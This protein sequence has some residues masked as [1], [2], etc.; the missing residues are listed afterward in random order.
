[1]IIRLVLFVFFA[2]VLFPEFGYGQGNY[3][4]PGNM[5][6]T[7]QPQSAP[8][9]SDNSEWSLPPLQTL[10]DLA[11][12]HSPVLKMADID[13]KVSENGLKDLHRE[14]MRRINF[15][16]DA[17]YGSMLDYSRLVTMPTENPATVMMSY[18]VGATAVVS[19]ADLFDRKRTKQLSKWRIE[20][21]QITKE[22]AVNG[23]VQLVINAYFEVL[24]AQKTLA[25]NNELNLTASLVY[26][27]AKMDFTQNKI[28]MTEWA[29]EN[30]AYLTSQ[31]A[32][33]LQKY[34]VMRSIH[35]LEII[36][37]VELVKA[38]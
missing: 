10:I 33:D 5:P 35:I 29:R 2:Q 20:Q 12:K 37:G 11:V 31:N 13:I 3:M 34:V 24:T 1:M 38:I 28:S 22:E 17:R 15:M 25:L 8:A 36:V 7:Q 6:A 14:W 23:L 19:L 18:G 30:E 21:A 16:A 4:R 27:K 26:D 32:V 9:G